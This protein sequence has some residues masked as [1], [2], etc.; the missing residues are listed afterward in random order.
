MNGYEYA[1]LLV[2]VPKV[3][4]VLEVASVIAGSL[5]F[6]SG[7]VGGLTYGDSYV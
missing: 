1:V 4:T 6:M 3:G 2:T 7:L 5:A